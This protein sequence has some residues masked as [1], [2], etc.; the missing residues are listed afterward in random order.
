MEQESG[1]NLNLCG[2]EHGGARP[3][4]HRSMKEGPNSKLGLSSLVDGESAL[5]DEF[6]C[7]EF[8]LD[9]DH[10]LIPL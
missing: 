6:W 3:S 10:V 7:V 1:R 2:R 8:T 9:V 4:L 5:F